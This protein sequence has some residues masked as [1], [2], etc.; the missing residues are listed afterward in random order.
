[1][2]PSKGS[3]LFIKTGLSDTCISLVGRGLWSTLNKNMEK[4]LVLRNRCMSEGLRAEI[5]NYMGLYIL[6]LG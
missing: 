2:V 1:M 4:E 3:H 5:D 6:R